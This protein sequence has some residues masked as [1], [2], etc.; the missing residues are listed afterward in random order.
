VDFNNL[1]SVFFIGIGGI[2]MSALARYFKQMGLEINGYDRTPTKL[3]QELINEGID[4]FFDDNIELI[5]PAFRQ[6]ETTLVV[7][8][9]AIPKEH[10]QLNFFKN[11]GFEVLKRAEVLGSISKNYKT[12]AVAGTHGKT[13]VS[14]I[15]SHLL[16]CS[17]LGCNAF[18]G[19]I[20]K[21][22]QSNLILSE[23][24]DYMV[25][26]ADEFDRSFLKLFPYF[27]VI[28]ATD[29][30]H[31]DIY[32]NSDNMLKSFQDF[33][34]QIDSKGVLF[35]KRHLYQTFID[36]S[37]RLLFTYALNENADFYAKNIRHEN[38]I[39]RFDLKTPMGELH[40]FTIGMPG[41]VNVENAV[42]AL[43]VALTA[44]ANVNVLRQALAQFSGIARRFD[45]RINNS[46]LVYIDDYAH[47]PEEL[48]AIIHSVKNIYPNKKITGIFQ[49]H[50]YSRTRDFAEGF[51]RS[52]SLL[53]QVVLLDIYPARELPIE[54]VSSQI[55]FDKIL[56][57]NKIFCKKEE[58]LSVLKNQN[59]EVLLT[60]GAGDIDKMVEPI[61]N[62]FLTKLNC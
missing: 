45:Y 19:G 1:N 14:T 34:K 26:E 38:E 59:I 39:Y 23:Q 11:S 21:N 3:T 37:A 50:L 7:F 42:A 10:L 15:I 53:D 12:V 62:Y 20:S 29:A 60:L 40:N 48:K 61:E 47:H 33:S 22:Y 32:Q 28:T 49:P 24:S 44:G 6:K 17:H 56:L 18:V 41:L 27:A 52:L 36:T 51:A 2:G 46:E 8:T 35:V 57:K 31:L 55:I 25:V 5:S 43:A 58:L 16:Y 4:V 13:T 9:P 54:G 30:D